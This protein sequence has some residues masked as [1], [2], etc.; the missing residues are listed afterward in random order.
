MNQAV[1]IAESEIEPDLVPAAEPDRRALRYAVPLVLA[2]GWGALI[3]CSAIFLFDEAKI[4]RA[5]AATERTPIVE[6]AGVVAVPPHAVAAVQAA[7]RREDA[8]PATTVAEPKRAPAILKTVAVPAPPP[9]MVRAPVATPARPDF[10]GV[11]GPNAIACGAR[12][13]RRGFIQAT[14]TEDGAKAGRVECRFRNGRRD[15]LAWATTADCSDRG[16]RW[17]SQVRLVVD[18]D[19]LTWTSGKGPANYVRCGRKD[20]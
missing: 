13:R 8:E 3:S 1:A 2:A 15:G 6:P 12:S 4:D 10:I 20:G 7:T 18:G 5:A 11:W 19:H 9:E 17:T 14:I 16:R